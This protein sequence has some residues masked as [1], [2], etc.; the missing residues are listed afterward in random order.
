L[1]KI[2]DIAAKK[3][4]IIT[5]INLRDFELD[6]KHVIDKLLTAFKDEDI[7][8]ALI[9]GFALG[10]LGIQ[11]ATV[12]IDFL[13]HRDDLEKVHAIMTGL[14]YQ[15]PFHTENVSQYVSADTVFGEVDFLHAF[16]EISTGML[17][18]AENNKI[19]NGTLSIK[20]LRIE[21]LIGLKVQAMAND[22][23]RKEIDLS[24]IRAL[25]DLHKTVVDW[26]LLEQYFSMF[27]FQELFKKL[28]KAGE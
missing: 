16:R 14:G 21:D 8:Y 19:F 3:G 10:A 9:G 27:G 6:F 23:A 26:P 11:R 12:D 1:N 18:R 2:L 22:D 25:I 28:R 5:T 15:R 24:D 20:I 13:V 17:Q 7:R 4:T